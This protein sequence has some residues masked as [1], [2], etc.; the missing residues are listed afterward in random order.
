M[1]VHY[2]FLIYLGFLSCVQMNGQAI[3][4]NQVSGYQTPE[5]ASEIAE[6]VAEL[7]KEVAQ[8]R[9]KLN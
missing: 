1:K 8:L 2:S 3:P 4:P 9:N 5:Q 7:R 6:E